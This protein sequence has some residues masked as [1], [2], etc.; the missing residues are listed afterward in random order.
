MTPFEL[1][2]L[3]H[4]YCIAGDH[5]VVLRNPPVWAETRKWMFDEGLLVPTIDNRSC[6]TYTTGKRANVLIEH[7]LNLPLP[8]YQMPKEAK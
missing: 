8:E 3:L 7:I 5:E 1:D 2:I 4:Y 6:A